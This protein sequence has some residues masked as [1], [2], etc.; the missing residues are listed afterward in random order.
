MT[1]Y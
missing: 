1:M